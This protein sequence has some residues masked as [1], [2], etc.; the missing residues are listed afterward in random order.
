V[1][2][3]RRGALA[4]T[5][6]LATASTAGVVTVATTAPSYAAD[7]SVPG[8]MST[9][10]VDTSSFSIPVPA[11]TTPSAITAVLNQPEVVPDATVAFSV[12]GRPALSVPSTLY[13]KITIPVTAA[14]VI[15]DGTIGLTMTTQAAAVPGAACVPSAGSASLRKLGLT[16]TGTETAPT[17]AGDFFPRSSSGIVVQIPQDAEPTL[18]EAGLTAVAALSYR[19]GEH[20]LVTLDTKPPTAPTATARIVSLVPGRAGEVTTTFGAEPTTGVPTLTLTGQGD[21][22]VN[23][24]RTLSSD[25]LSLGGSNASDPSQQARAR[26]TNDE[27]TLA[28]LGESSLSL[29]GYGS[30]TREVELRQ[31]DFGGPVDRMDLHLEGT[32]TAF[33]AASG[34]RLDVKVNGDLIGS[35]TLGEDSTFTLD[36]VV[37]AGKLRSVND[38]DLTLSATAPDGSACTP[39][40][41]P[42]AEVDVNTAV[43][44]VTVSRG[45]GQV[46]G[47]Q[48]YPQAFEG[49]VPVA[50]KAPEGRQAN[51]AINAAAI[52]STLQHAAGSPLEIQVMDPDD[53]LAD[54]RNGLMVGALQAEADSLGAPL[55]L[56]AKRELN[57]ADGKFEVTSQ[58]QFSAF[59][60]IDHDDRLVLMLGSWRP[61][62]SAADG[63]LA[64]KAVGYVV[65]T[66][67]ADLTGDLVVAD[68]SQDAYSAESLTL[69]PHAEP[70]PEK[71]Y[72]R[73]FIAVI[74][75]LL[76]LL[77]LQVVIA[78]RRDRRVSREEREGGPAYVEDEPADHEVDELGDVDDLAVLE[79]VDRDEDEDDTE[80][81]DELEEDADD[82]DFVLFEEREDEPQED[83]EDDGEEDD[84]EDDEPADEE[85]PA[86]RTRPSG[87]RGPERRRGPRDPRSG[88][89]P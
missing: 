20:A 48:L 83:A 58:D 87:Y 80:L 86:P 13:R 10:S 32:H 60:A 40:S 36:A 51:P 69:A 30:T 15:A 9:A 44:T 43:S 2:T 25:T 33:A 21:A 31:D 50:L 26:N 53:F 79:D 39:A 59:E 35:T 12:N 16:F 38:L 55:K 18:I 5:A 47:F 75:V 6:L 61:G 3:Y 49:V 45:Y 78:I 76:A 11:G 64:R 84:A 67:W 7:T 62:N 72:A 46:E 77:A 42:A 81:E 71:S 57:R 89:R 88:R 70:E 23:A 1:R 27:R 85:K 73:W 74:A 56:G 37:P 52:I 28:S 17:G 19:Y 63:E 41:I 66:G 14:D 34:A 65:S 82:D 4:L 24:A 29:S 22:M 8:T 68:A 54:N